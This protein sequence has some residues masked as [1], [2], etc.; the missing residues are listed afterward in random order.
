MTTKSLPS[1]ARPTTITFVA[2]RITKIINWPFTHRYSAPIWLALRLYVGWI[3]FQMSIGKFAAGWLSSDP[4][5]AILKQVGAAF[6]VRHI[7]SASAAAGA[8]SEDGAL[9]CYS[10]AV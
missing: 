5:G 8:T 2:K 7:S 3:W 9:I 6:T 10:C 4:T 1:M